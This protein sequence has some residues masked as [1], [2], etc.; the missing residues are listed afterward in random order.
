MYIIIYS[1]INWL[2]FV[3]FSSFCWQVKNHTNANGKAVRGVLPD[4]TS[5]LDTTEST[6][7][8]SRSNANSVT[9]DSHD[10][11]TW[12]CIW[13]VITNKLECNNCHTYLFFSLLSFFSSNC[14]QFYLMMIR[15]VKLMYTSW[16]FIRLEQLIEMNLPQCKK[17]IENCFF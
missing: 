2:K 1:C 16:D 15:L 7:V 17:T 14:T 12:H 10:Q 13:N 11:I 3:F 4:Q 9:E 5:W 6:Q 8:P